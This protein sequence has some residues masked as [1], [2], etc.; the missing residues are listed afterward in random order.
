MAIWACSLCKRRRFRGRHTIS[1]QENARQ[2]AQQI[3]IYG[4]GTVASCGQDEDAIIVYE[5]PSTHGRISGA[6]LFTRDRFPRIYGKLNPTDHRY[7]RKIQRKPRGCPPNSRPHHPERA[8]LWVGRSG[9]A[10]SWRP[11]QPAIIKPVHETR[12]VNNQQQIRVFPMNFT[13][14]TPKA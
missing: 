1:A 9:L 3:S 14:V 7:A 6:R 12:S 5:T 4:V 10:G 11:M 2:A 8:K 13:W